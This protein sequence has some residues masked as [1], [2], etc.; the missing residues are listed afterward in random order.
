MSIYI[1]YFYPVKLFRFWRNTPTLRRGFDGVN[2]LPNFYSRR[3][4][5]ILIAAAVFLIAAILAS[6]WYFK[7]YP[8]RDSL[9][10]RAPADAVLYAHFNL[11]NGAADYD[12]LNLPLLYGGV[13]QWFDWPAG[14]FAKNILPLVKNEL[15]IVMAPVVKSASESSAPSGETPTGE[16][17]K[18]EL[19]L[20]KAILFNLNSKNKNDLA[21]LKALGLPFA[22]IKN[23]LVVADSELTLNEITGV[24]EQN[25]LA[26]RPS[27][28]DGLKKAGDQSL[29]KGY[30]SVETLDEFFKQK[31]SAALL[32]ADLNLLF[33]RLSAAWLEQQNSQQIYFSLKKEADGFSFRLSG[34]NK[35]A[36][37][38]VAKSRLIKSVP[39]NTA[40]AL[41]G[42]DWQQLMGS[43]EKTFSEVDPGLNS[44][45]TNYEK[46]YRF[47]WQNDLAPLLSGA[48]EL[49]VMKEANQKTEFILS[50]TPPNVDEQKI[51]K[52]EDI[53]KEYLAY[54]APTEQARVLPD[55]SKVI[56]QIADPGKFNFQNADPADLKIKFIKEDG[57]PFEFLYTTLNQS[58]LV[59]SNSLE[60]FKI[61]E[62]N[63]QKP[64]PDWLNLNRAIKVSFFDRGQEAALVNLKELKLT[65]PLAEL[66]A[67]FN[68]LAVVNTREGIKGTIY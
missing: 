21:V 30:L 42:F 59:F 19:V 68:W 39:P 27:V 49:L 15:A 58:Q 54:R 18:N 46:L 28:K 20:G 31:N 35:N 14:Q 67:G 10:K 11:M 23:Q 8:Y 45:K 5:I 44:F 33:L 64:G 38:S 9:V 57:L 56:E 26:N 32:S 41:V 37:F 55:K 34:A 1:K 29:A 65:G 61:F 48:G 50:A 24:S 47:S 62:S 2:K 22:Q 51:S 40:I 12:R 36:A 63:Q 52:L 66:L 25:N 60:K 17:G 16:R 7:I 13:D 53:V 4:K 6:V 3:N 43:L